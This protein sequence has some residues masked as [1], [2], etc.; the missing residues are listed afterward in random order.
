MQKS[1]RILFFIFEGSTDVTSLGRYLEI[2]FNSDDCKVISRSARGDVTSD[3]ETTSD[4]LLS[5]IKEIVD[6]F[7]AKQ[8]ISYGDL[9]G[10]VQVIDT[11]GAYVSEK[12]IITSDYAHPFIDV[13]KGVIKTRDR[14]GIADRNL[15]KR[16]LVDLLV[17]FD[18]IE[19]VPYRVFY[20]SSDLEHVLHN[21]ANCTKRSDKIRLANSF[22]LRYAA[23]QQGFIRFMTESDFTVKGGYLESWDFIRDEKNDSRSLERHTNL[24]LLF[25]LD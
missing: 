7:C 12:R 3:W 4:N 14:W 10:I 19:G 25:D 5:R 20:M 15:D 9:L 13:G 1:K 17:E 2:H 22:A 23:D 8:K 24:G 6:D 18:E 11:D 16:E 21:R